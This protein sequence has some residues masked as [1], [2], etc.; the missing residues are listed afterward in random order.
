MTNVCALSFHDTTRR[1]V[2]NE[3]GKL[4]RKRLRCVNLKIERVRSV[5]EEY[6]SKKFS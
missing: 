5:R 2:E 6:D 3:K 4:S 1:Y